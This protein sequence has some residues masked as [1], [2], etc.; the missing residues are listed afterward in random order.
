MSSNSVLPYY[1][2]CPGWADENMVG[3]FYSTSNRQR[4]LGQYASV[5]NAVEANNTFYGL[6]KHETAKRWAAATSASADGFQFVFK[7]PSTISH[8]KQLRNAGHETAEFLKLLEIFHEAKQLGPAFLQLPPFFDGRQLPDL[9]NFLKQLPKEFH[10][11]VETRHADYFDQ[12]PI[13]REFTQLLTE[14]KIDRMLFDSRP[15]FSEKPT[16]KW[17]T[18]AQQRKPESPV[19]QTV[20]ATRPVLR[21]IGRNEIPTVRPWMEQWAKIVA[22]WIAGGLTPYIFTHAPDNQYAPLAAEQFH[23]ILTELISD[24]PP[25]PKWPARKVQQQQALF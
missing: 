4:W 5:F 11:S 22:G 20:T 13:E 12:G 3:S 10:Y 21:L 16:D 24:L 18:I 6:P 7:F 17:E 23:A 25:L 1:L 2:G 15:L 14:L 19:R 8:E 9:A